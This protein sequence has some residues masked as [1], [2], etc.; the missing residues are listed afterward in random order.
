MFDLIAFRVVAEEYSGILNQLL[1]NA[2]YIAARREAVFDM[3]QQVYLK[4]RDEDL[5][6]ENDAWLYRMREIL[7]QDSDR[8][9]QRKNEAYSTRTDLD[10]KGQDLIGQETCLAKLQALENLIKRDT[11]VPS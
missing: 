11:S 10:G 1:A 7:Q 6:C 2:N 3:L 4:V 5:K 8:S 9:R